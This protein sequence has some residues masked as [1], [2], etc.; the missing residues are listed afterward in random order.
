[1]SQVN[2]KLKCVTESEL[3]KKLGDVGLQAT[4]NKTA[5]HAAPLLSR[6]Q[7]YMPL[8]TFH[9]E[10]HILNIIGW[11]DWLTEPI[12]ESMSPLEAALCLLS[13]YT[14]DLGM[15]LSRE[16]HQELVGGN[17]RDF[18]RFRHG[19]QEAS[20]QI[21]RLYCEGKRPAAQ[22]IENHLITGYLRG[23]H[24]DQR[25]HR[26]K[27]QLNEIVEVS[28]DS[29]L[30][31][32]GSFDFRFQLELISIS[33]NQKV[34]WLRKQLTSGLTTEEGDVETNFVL[35]S[36]VLRLADIMDFDASRTPEILFRHL[37][38]EDNVGD[39]E[40]DQCAFVAKSI[41]ESRRE[42]R[43]HLAV[44]GID[45]DAD[46]NAVTY[47]ATQCPHPATHKTILTFVDL[48]NSEVQNAQTELLDRIRPREGI[49]GLR[50]P[51]VKADVQPKNG[52]YIYKD[53]SF[54]I[55]QEAIMN[56]L[57]GESLY[58]DPSLCIRELLQNALDAVELRDLRHQFSREKREQRTPGRF[59]DAD[60]RPQ[61][62]A[63][64]LTWATIRRA[65]VGGSRFPTMASA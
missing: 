56:L 43:K 61:E 20:A 44:S 58:G 34:D 46:R 40:L 9:N 1:M 12:R 31:N 47:Q 64:T 15:A 60:G 25:A 24:S 41:E 39:L 26:M 4:V 55:D 7:D 10:R 11:M 5:T 30:F 13:A 6:V 52:T 37:G 16:Q 2:L 3:Y 38:L 35:P 33:H 17:D 14:H 19:H 36:L 59:F 63:V 57:M 65:N 51:E 50:L 8:Y 28:G 32:Y 49:K 62:F 45:C 21:D 29:N 27:E 48:I 22:V 54:Q 23:T 53:W 18:E 42:W